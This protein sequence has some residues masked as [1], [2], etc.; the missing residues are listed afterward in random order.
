MYYRDIFLQCIAVMY[1]QYNLQ[2]SLQ[3]SERR[4]IIYND[5]KS[6][7]MSCWPWTSLL[8]DISIPNPNFSQW[9]GECW[10]L[11]SQREEPRAWSPHQHLRAQ[12]SS[13]LQGSAT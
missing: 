9:S 2:Y 4:H 1:L 3:A 8:N 7:G 12:P 6:A 5:D 13:T 10:K 11:T